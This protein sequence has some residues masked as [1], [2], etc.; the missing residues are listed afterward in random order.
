MSRLLA[1]S[2]VLA[3]L[4]APALAQTATPA[5]P[6][7][8][9]NFTAVAEMPTMLDPSKLDSFA[10]ELKDAQIDTTFTLSCSA[11]HS[12]L[13][14]LSHANKVCAFEKGSN[15][16]VFNPK[17]NAW[18]PRTQY[19]GTYTVT[20]DGTTD[21]KSLVVS[22]LPQGNQA[23]FGGSLNLKPEQTSGGAEALKDSILKKLKGQSSS[24]V[25]DRT[26][27]IDF[28]N[29][30]VPSAGLPS[31]K[32]CTWQGNGVFS[33][34]TFSWYYNVSAICADQRYDFKGNMPFIGDSS[35]EGTTSYNLV[36]TLN[37]ADAQSDDALFTDSADD[38]L[39]TDVV[40]I[41]GK[42]DMKNTHIDHITLDNAPLDTPQH[43]EASGTITGNGVPLPVVR[44]FVTLIGL[45]PSTYFGP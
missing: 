26:D 40:G 31:D 43:V 9:V 6:P 23:Q 42:I 16:Q 8:A 24:P 37:G 36:L 14:G 13:F 12:A 21:A 4:S 1:V 27:T 18:Q 41:T 28:N 15:G 30:Y 34:Q 35:Q 25:D 3:L 10:V 22:Y 33:Y 11:G 32:G 20:G 19:L 2:A 44:S 17:K 39:F 45:L 38:S 7:A 29:F 5:T